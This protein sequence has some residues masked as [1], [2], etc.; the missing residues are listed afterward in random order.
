MSFCQCI[1]YR[2]RSNR[3]VYCNAVDCIHWLIHQQWFIISSILCSRHGPEFDYHGCSLIVYLPTFYFIFYY[4]PLL[5]QVKSKNDFLLWSIRHL[6]NTEFHFNTMHGEVYR[7][8]PSGYLPEDEWTHLA[9]TYNS[10]TGV[11]NTYVNGAEISSIR[12]TTST[13]LNSASCE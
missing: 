10:E 1:W 8:T 5:L 6:S 11:V 3:F 7:Y 2:W 13:N 9:A 4:R 12:M